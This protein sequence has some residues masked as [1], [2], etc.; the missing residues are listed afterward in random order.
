MDPS[1]KKEQPKYEYGKPK[2]SRGANHTSDQKDNKTGFSLTMVD[3]FVRTPKGLAIT[4]VFVLFPVLTL[5]GLLASVTTSSDKRNTPDSKHNNELGKAESHPSSRKAI[6]SEYALT[7]YT[8]G[9]YP[10][11]FEAFGSRISD[12]ERF[13]RAAAE[14]VASSSTCD[15]IDV[16]EVSQ[17]RSSLADLHFFLDCGNGTRFRFS[18]SE[19]VDTTIPALSETDKA[20]S[21]SNTRSACEDLIRNNAT[22]PATVKIHRFMGTSTYKAPSSGNVVVT[23]DFDAKNAFGT[24]IGYQA[25]CYFKPGIAVGTVEINQRLR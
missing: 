19:L 6:I 11:L 8:Q 16:V 22:I 23:M 2:A 5:V 1:S 20:W 10:K 18:E 4:F 17:E 15:R 12:I 25:K 13:R 14:K 24:Q 3:N 21:E 9:Q 7:P